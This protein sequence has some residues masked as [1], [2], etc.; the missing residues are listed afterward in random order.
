MYIYVNMYIHT[1]TNICTCIYIYT[2]V[3]QKC[4]K[5][6]KLYAYTFLG[7]H[8]YINTYI[9][10]YI[11]VHTNMYIYLLVKTVQN[12]TTHCS[13]DRPTNLF[14]GTVLYTCDSQIYIHI[15][16]YIYIYHMYIYIHIHCSVD[17]NSPPLFYVATKT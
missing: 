17:R 16:I 15:C 13:A 5:M 12:C 2:F 7:I 3:S 4:T 8:I 11:Y 9:H 6:Y 1:L 14:F 10:K